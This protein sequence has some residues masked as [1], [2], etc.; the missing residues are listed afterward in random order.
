MISVWESH[1]FILHFFRFKHFPNI[2]FSHKNHAIELTTTAVSR[3]MTTTTTTL[4]TKMKTATEA[5]TTVNLSSKKCPSFH[6]QNTLNV[7]RMLKTHFDLF[8]T[9]QNRE[10]NSGY[11]KLKWKMFHINSS[12]KTALSNCQNEKR[13]AFDGCFSS[14]F[15]VLLKVRL[16]ISHNY[17]GFKLKLDTSLLMKR[18]CFAV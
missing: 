14:S 13:H 1:T 2:F 6:M 9:I 5:R 10:C 17:F 15:V 11:S 3:I 18:N 12:G 4:Q 7:G 16:L 8:I